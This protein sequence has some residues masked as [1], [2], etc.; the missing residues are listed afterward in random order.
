MPKRIALTA[1]LL[2]AGC[3]RNPAREA[4]A[5]DTV[6]AHQVIEEMIDTPSTAKYQSTRTVAAVGNYR[7]VHV[8]LD[9]QNKFGAM[10][11]KSVCVTFFFEGDNIRWDKQDALMEC[12]KPPTAAELEAVKVANGW[13]Q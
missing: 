6:A 3:D 4:A 12:S 1:L 7:I 2:L 8:V 5:R 9:A 11:R 13:P 10:L